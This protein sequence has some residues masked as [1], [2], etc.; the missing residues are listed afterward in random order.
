MFKTIKTAEQ[1]AEEKQKQK[2]QQRIDELKQFLKETDY[3]VL[4]DYDKD[5]SEIISQRQSF[6]E[7]IR[8]L[9]FKME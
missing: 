3:I 1:L 9:E 2:D 5:K 8:M 7:E 6:R 4:P